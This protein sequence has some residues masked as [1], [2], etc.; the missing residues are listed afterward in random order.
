VMEEIN[1]RPA[2]GDGAAEGAAGG[3]RLARAVFM[4]RQGPGGRGRGRRVRGRGG[5]KARSG[6][7][8][9]RV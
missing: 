3:G 6:W 5:E 7:T 1:S 2:D 4:G 8:K 9:V